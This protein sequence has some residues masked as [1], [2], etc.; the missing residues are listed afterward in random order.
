MHLISSCVQVQI[1]AK[2]AVKQTKK[3]LFT[4]NIR[5]FQSRHLPLATPLLGQQ[6]KYKNEHVV[7]N[8]ISL[9]TSIK[10]YTAH[11]Y[12][13]NLSQ[14]QPTRP[15]NQKSY[16]CISRESLVSGTRPRKDDLFLSALRSTDV[17]AGEKY[18][19]CGR[20]QIS[21]IIADIYGNY[22]SPNYCVF[23]LKTDEKS[24]VCSILGSVKTFRC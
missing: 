20:S 5:E 2:F 15:I 8:N 18:L 12:Y 17:T 11:A 14:P 22:S 19:G 6:N 10:R 23:Y 13:F 3:Y 7:H 16:I 24:R 21:N 4:F 9:M 1:Q